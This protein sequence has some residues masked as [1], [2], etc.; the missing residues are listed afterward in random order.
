M[1]IPIDTWE[2]CGARAT[3]VDTTIISLKVTDNGDLLGSISLKL[4]VDDYGF[5]ASPDFEAAYGERRLGLSGRDQVF[6]RVKIATQRR[7]NENPQAALFIES[8]NRPTH[9]AHLIVHPDVEGRTVADY[10]KAAKEGLEVYFDTLLQHLG[11]T[12]ASLKLQMIPVERQMSAATGGSA[13]SL[14]RSLAQPEKGVEE[15]AIESDVRLADIG[16][17]SEVKTEILQL[18]RLFQNPKHFALFGVEPPRG[19]LFSGPPGTGKTMFAKAMCNELGVKFYHVSTSDVLNSLYGESE[20]RLAEIFDKVET[21]CVVF[22]DELEAL[23]PDRDMASEPSRRVLTELLRKLDGMGSRPGILF[24]GATNKPEMLDPAITRAGRLDRTITIGTPDIAAREE[25]FK[26]CVERAQRHS[27][28]D[29]ESLRRLDCPQ[30]AQNTEGLV[31]ADIQEIMRRIVFDLA[32]SRLSRDETPPSSS[33]ANEPWYP[34]TDNALL[35]VSSYKA[36]LERKR[37]R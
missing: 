35:R 10:L 18:I 14:L 34:T 27:A 8:L 33:I 19:I 25:I 12:D 29:L 17:Y 13:G 28:S 15:L 24:L 5:H 37:G 2:R 22:V 4:T 23:A 32:D 3:A 16:G 9:S 1:E 7:L 6:D 20:K 26:V 11:V 30:L 31:G 36:E 21:P